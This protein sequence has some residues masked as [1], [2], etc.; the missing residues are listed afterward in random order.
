[1]K[2]VKIEKEGKHLNT[3]AKYHV[4]KISKNRLHMSDA[5]IDDVCNTIF[6]SIARSKHKI[7]PHAHYK[8]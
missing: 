3:L 4:H 7:A 8:G 1:M 2:V 5:H 6:K